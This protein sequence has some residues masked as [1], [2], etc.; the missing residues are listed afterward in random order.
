VEGRRSTWEYEGQR[1]RVIQTVGLVV[2]EQTG[3]IDTCLV[4]YRIENGDNVPHRVGLRFLLDTFIGNNDG[5][6]FLIPGHRQLCSTTAD[7]RRAEDVPDF[8][9]AYEFDDL[10]RPGTVAQV[11]LRLAGM[12]APSRVTLGAWPNPK[13]RIATARQEKTLWEVPL[14]SLRTL[15]DSAVTMYWSER[16]V[17]AGGAR[18]MAFTYGLGSVSSGDT[19]G[20]MALSVGGSFTPRGEFT[21][22]ASVR[23]PAGGQ[24]L[25]LQLPEGFERIGGA[26]VERV[27]PLPADGSTRISPVTWRVRAGPSA[28]EFPLT[29]LSSTGG[30]VMRKVQIKVRGIFGN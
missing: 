2:G 7:F 13:L 15:N 18:E 26:E 21:L 29:V 6:P 17:E 20:A 4:H 19:G 8:I 9:E 22:T 3:R 11:R 24:T 1:V 30:K 27:P 10:E 5:V 14:V 25:R 23:D 16:Q 12:E 28:G